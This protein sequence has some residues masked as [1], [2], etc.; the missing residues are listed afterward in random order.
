MFRC[1]HCHRV[2]EDIREC[3]RHVQ[4]RNHG[5]YCRVKVLRHCHHEDHSIVIRDNINVETR[6]RKMWSTFEHIGGRERMEDF[7]LVDEEMGVVA[8]FDGYVFM[9]RCLSTTH[10]HHHQT[11]TREISLQEQFEIRFETF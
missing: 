9:F 1:E 2:F 6:R 7:L 11:D 5:T 8:V 4:S 10:H 3:D